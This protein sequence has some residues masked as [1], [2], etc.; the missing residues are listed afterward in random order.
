MRI[1][2]LAPSNTEILFA[3]G[4]GDQI[5][6]RTAYCDYP[7]VAKAI[8]KIGDWVN[9]DIDV[10]KKLEPDLILTSTIVQEKLAERM[11]K[12]KLPVYH[13]DPKKLSDVIASIERIGELVDKTMEARTLLVCSLFSASFAS[14]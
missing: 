13:L 10:I 12:L 11:K 6:A 2:S 9:P 14:K 7:P 1:V 3:I 4:A 5:I 8:P